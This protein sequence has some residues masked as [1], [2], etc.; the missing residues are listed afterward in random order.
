M[1]WYTGDPLFDTVLAIALALIPLTVAGLFFMKAPYGRFAGEG[2]LG[3]GL[4]P[5][6]GW[7][8]MELPATVVFWITYLSGPRRFESVPMV[9]AA[10]WGFHYLNRG[11]VFPALMRVPKGQKGTFGWV[12]ILSGWGVTSMHGYLNGAF[13]SRLG[14]HLVDGWLSDPRFLIGIAIYAFGF[15]L[16]VHS[17]HVL[18][19]LRSREEVAAAKKVYRVP[20]GGGYALV[21]N[22]SYLGEL[23]AWA[24]FA[25]F[26]WS[27]PGVFIFGITA[28]N[29][30]P[31]ALSNHRW[32]KERF[33]DYPEARK[34]LIPYVL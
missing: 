17:D 26:T 23:I 7:F 11:F 20:Y 32:Y 14:A 2:S 8:L 27:L 21:S 30:V 10:L 34:A 5:R 3:L 19:N 6:L 18:R 24:G 33:D 31:R 28:A 25:L 1:R 9:L 4:D 16:N 15:A 12:V 13:Y 29:L 22:P